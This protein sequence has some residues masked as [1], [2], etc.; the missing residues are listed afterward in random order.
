MRET[1]SLPVLNADL[2]Q[3]R[4]GIDSL[5]ETG[6]VVEVRLLKTRR[7]TVSGYFDDLSKLADSVWQADR[8]KTSVYYTLNPVDSRLLGRAYNQLHEYAEHT[9]GDRDVLRRRWAPVDIDAVRPAGVS[10]TDEEHEQAIQLAQLIAMEMEHTLGKPQI[11]ADSGNG[12][13]LLY[14]VDLANSPESDRKIERML[15]ILDKRYST[16]KFKIDQSVANAARIWK[17]YGTVARKGDSTPA[18]PH[19]IA[20][21]LEVAR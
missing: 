19:R 17:C 8:Y 21:I 9:T 4:F 12:A 6:S 16:D 1:N 18:Q 3:I 14:R 10:A 13:H 20:R 7:G 5:F 15:S 2:Q 11:T